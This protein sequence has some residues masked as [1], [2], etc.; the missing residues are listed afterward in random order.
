MDEEESKAA[1]E[2]SKKAAEEA[3]KKAAEES[4]QAEEARKAAERAAKELANARTEAIEEIE[5]YVN[6]DDYP[7]ETK[8]KI[9]AIIGS[10]KSTISDESI[11]TTVSAIENMVARTKQQID[12]CI[13]EMS[14]TPPPDESSS[15]ESSNNEISEET[16]PEDDE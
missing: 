12:E 11:L 4:R 7:S 10:A 9:Q 8:G 15:D 3:S 5:S 2:A 14:E 16:T 6:P 13:E 1:E